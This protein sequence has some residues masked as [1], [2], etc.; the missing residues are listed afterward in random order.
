MAL[1][2]VQG[3]QIESPVDIAAV[4]L[5]GV[6][7]IG[8]LNATRINVTG[9]TTFTNALEIDSSN[10]VIVGG[11]T[12][13]VGDSPFQVYTSD[14]IH[15]AIRFTSP[16]SNGFAIL[17]DAYQ[18]DESQI[19][20]GISYSSASLVLST[21][22]KVSGTA[23]NTYLSSQDTFS[24]RP[25]VIKMN[26]QGILTYLTADSSATTTT[27]S[28]VTV[29]ERLRIHS[30]G[31]VSAPYGIELGS[32]LDATAANTIDDYEEG[33]FSPQVVGGVTGTPTYANQYGWYT[34][35]GRVVSVY[36]Y[37]RFASS[38]NTG[39]GTIMQVGNFPFAF[40]NTVSSAAY[41]RGFGLCNYHNIPGFT[42]ANVTLYGGGSTNTFASCYQ[43]N[44][45]VATTSAVNS[46]YLIG[47][48]EYFTA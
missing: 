41:Q 10:R 7:T 13:K 16:S 35:V 22:V 3:A 43:G 31:T 4:N 37:L 46:K 47:G 40:S 2:K 45:T 21:S 33:E 19:N 39:D 18:S 27:D 11:N 1:S 44:S 8:D 6:S 42:S 48:M 24:A 17:G 25:G 15:P 28:E 20:M 5:T 30:G 36:F 23:D 14:K 32:G 12:T 34:K 29:T 26:H 38:G 9:V